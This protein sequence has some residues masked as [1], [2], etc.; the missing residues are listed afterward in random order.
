MPLL[1][2]ADRAAVGVAQLQLTLTYYDEYGDARASTVS[3]GF[4]AARSPSPL[5]A[6]KLL[7]GTLPYGLNSML[8]ISIVNLGDAAAVDVSVDATPGAGVYVLEAARVGVRRVEAGCS[9]EIPFTV[10]AAPTESSATI[11]FRLEYYDESGERYADALQVSFNVTRSDPSVTLTPLNRTLYPN[12]V[13]RVVVLV[14][15]AGSAEARNV[16]VALTSQSPEIGAVVGPSTVNLGSLAAGAS[17]EVPF[18][19]FVRARRAPR[20]AGRPARL[21]SAVQLLEGRLLRVYLAVTTNELRHC[22]N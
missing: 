17:A 10:R 14:R 6:V 1:V 8:V 4:E 5:L 11:T 20:S 18:D 12:R 19:V 3:V 21:T 15:N 16:T 7:N 22:V 9:V 13:N 2:R